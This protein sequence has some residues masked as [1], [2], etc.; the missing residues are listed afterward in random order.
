MKKR[1]AILERE[2]VRLGVGLTDKNDAEKRRDIELIK[3]I[4]DVF[5]NYDSKINEL[6]K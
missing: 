2:I 5:M 1:R 4:A 3:K 6:Y